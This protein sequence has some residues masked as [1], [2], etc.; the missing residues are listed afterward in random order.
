M[1]TMLTAMT[2]MSIT[3]AAAA[4]TTM[5][6]TSADVVIT[7]NIMNDAAAMITGKSPQRLLKRRKC[8]SRRY[9]LTAA[10]CLRRG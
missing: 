5:S 1:G 8:R 4:M 9:W 6:I 2:I 3:S 7:M 10:C